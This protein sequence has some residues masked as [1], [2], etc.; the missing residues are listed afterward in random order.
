M[1]RGGRRGVPLS[2]RRIL[3][4]YCFLNEIIDVL[5]FLLILHREFAVFEKRHP[6]PNQKTKH[7]MASKTLILQCVL[8]CLHQKH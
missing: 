1:M 7:T 3:K 2:S 6:T 5:S 4:N 8:L